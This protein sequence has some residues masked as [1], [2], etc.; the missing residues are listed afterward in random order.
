MSQG[1]PKQRW[2]AKGIKAIMFVCFVIILAGNKLLESAEV[3]YSLL[4]GGVSED[5]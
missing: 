4:L 1:S 2:W 3:D 5:N